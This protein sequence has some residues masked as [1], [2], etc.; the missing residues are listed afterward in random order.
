MS[1]LPSIKS[2][3]KEVSCDNECFALAKIYNF[4]KKFDKKTVQ[5][6]ECVSTT[7]EMVSTIN[8]DFWG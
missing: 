1:K 7:N 6:Q 4:L 2:L 8:Y 3:K 5:T